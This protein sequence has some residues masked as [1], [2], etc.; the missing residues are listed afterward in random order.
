M[1]LTTLEWIEAVEKLHHQNLSGS[2]P[3]AAGSLSVC[4]CP[5]LTRAVLLSQVSICWGS[6]SFS[7]SLLE[8]TTASRCLPSVRGQHHQRRA[9]SR[10]AGRAS[11]A[12][13]RA[14]PSRVLL[15]RSSSSLLHRY[16]RSGPAAP[17]F[18]S[19]LSSA[20]LAVAHTLPRA[21]PGS[22]IYPVR[23]KKPPLGCGGRRL[24]LRAPASPAEPRSEYTIERSCKLGRS[25]L[26]RA[27]LFAGSVFFCRLGHCRAF[28]RV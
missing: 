22:F 17:S 3:R 19:S 25:C 14:A 6:F 2:V 1:L 16:R 7:E 13:S 4:P 5:G 15:A 28:S 20:P 26:L 9:A 21:S 12:V 18:F 10:L 8:T 23:I 11:S 24:A 27:H